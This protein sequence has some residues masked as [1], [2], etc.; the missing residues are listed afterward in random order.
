MTPLSQEPVSAAAETVAT[1]REARS[2]LR[3]F[4]DQDEMS[5]EAQELLPR[6][7][8]ALDTL[9]AALERAERER[10]EAREALEGI[11]DVV[12]GWDVDPPRSRSYKERNGIIQRI[13]A[14]ALAA[15][16]GEGE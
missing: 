2:F 5:L 13:A 4:D 9:A 8:A 14:D 15:A 7:D 12:E 6:W 3:Y 1:V 10:D 16:E 11:R